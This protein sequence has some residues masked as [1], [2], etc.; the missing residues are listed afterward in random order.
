MRVSVVSLVSLSLLLS[1]G[2]AAAQTL[3]R[4]DPAAP[5]RVIVQGRWDTPVDRA[6]SIIFITRLSHLLR[7]ARVVLELSDANRAHA[8]ANTV[9][10]A[11]ATALTI[12]LVHQASTLPFFRDDTRVLVR[13]DDAGFSHLHRDLIARGELTAAVAAIPQATASPGVVVVPFTLA[14]FGGWPRNLRYHFEAI[15][16]TALPST[17]AA[18]AAVVVVVRHACA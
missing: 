10:N 14:A 1:A 4:A 6:S 11:N 15:T 7:S 12:T 8:G 2:S 5:R 17:A 13:A 16:Q 9:A 3:A 18:A